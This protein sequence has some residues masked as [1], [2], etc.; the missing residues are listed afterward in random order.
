[1]NTKLMALKSRS[2]CSRKAQENESEKQIRVMPTQAF[3]QL[4][5]W[6]YAKKRWGLRAHK[7]NFN[8]GLSKTKTREMH[9]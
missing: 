6:G 8:I 1:M 4:R 9:F 2:E 5:Q 7:N 3:Y